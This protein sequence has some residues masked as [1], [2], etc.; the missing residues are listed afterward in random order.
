MRTARSLSLA[1]VMCVACAGP[2]A[3]PAETPTASTPPAAGSSAVA[4]ATA[5]SVVAATPATSPILRFALTDVRSGERFTL[6]GF[7]GKTVIV[8]GMA[9]W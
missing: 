4:S 6:G 1:F 5:T 7:T 8:Q 3:V 9:V 2:R